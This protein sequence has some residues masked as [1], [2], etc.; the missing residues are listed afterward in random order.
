M[1]WVFVLFPLYLGSPIGAGMDFTDPQ[2]NPLPLYQLGQNIF[3][4]APGGTLTSAYA[5]S[6]PQ[7][8]SVSALDPAF[9]AAYISQWNVSIQHSIGAIDSVALS[10]LG[11]SGHRLPVMNDIS[12][13]QPTSDLFCNPAAKPWLRYSLIYYATSS[14]NSSYQAGIARY[15]H[16]MSHGLNLGFEYTLGKALTDAWQSTLNSVNQI[17]DCR[18]CDK[19]PATFDVRSRAVGSLVWE[20]PYG[21]GPIA[22]GW[23]LT[24]ITTF[25]T[26]QPILLTGPN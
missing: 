2:T 20:I 22:G 19:G 9:R 4:A 10:Y 25:Q 21:R 12:Q 15:S 5:A 23:S 24:A 26:G 6:L 3:P 1:P 11:S 13:C 17:T 16:R 18:R 14:G 7:G 8:V